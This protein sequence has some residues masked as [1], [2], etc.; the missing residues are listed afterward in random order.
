MS[1][2]ASV[3]INPSRLLRCMTA[4]LGIGIAVIGTRFAFLGFSGSAASGRTSGASNPFAPLEFSTPSSLIELALAALVILIGCCLLYSSA[5]RRK[6]FQL[7]I[8]GV[9]EI[10]LREHYTSAAVVPAKSSRE[11]PPPG[12]AV[13]LLVESTIWPNLLALRLRRKNGSLV[14]LI[15]LPGMM[16]AAD[17][18]ALVIAMQWI[19]SRDSADTA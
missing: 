1:L 12:E 2:A 17:F 16:T 3:V 5:C 9:G 15:V 14:N 7:D 6:S 19:A 4:A 11:N 13:Q 8:S 10:R 18:R